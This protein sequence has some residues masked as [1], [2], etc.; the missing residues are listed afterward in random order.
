MKVEITWDCFPRTFN[1]ES[2]ENDPY[3]DGITENHEPAY[4]EFVQAL[5]KLK[6]ESGESLKV[7][8]DV[9]ANIGIK[10]IPASYFTDISYA[11]E[12]NSIA[13][14]SLNSNIRTNGIKNIKTIHSAIGNSNQDQHFLENSA[15]GHIA[16]KGTIVQGQTM[17]SFL[18]TQGVAKVDLCKI[19]I[20]GF[21]FNALS[22]FDF[23]KSK[24]SAIWLEFNSWCLLAFGNTN[25]KSFLE[26]LVAEY[27]FVGQIQRFED[28]KLVV[29]E[30][31]SDNFL[32]FLH[33]NIVVN[34]SVD[35]LLLVPN[36]AEYE[37]FHPILNIIE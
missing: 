19:D 13:I 24:F 26:F 28:D 7:L 30:I 34:G 10:C 20:E 17:S 14:S 37:L 11:V 29:R 33:D 6:N 2:F 22:A 8:M 3:L 21:E 35:D 1:F 5:H 4:L 32:A 18:V 12:A 27:F 9:G 36:Q 23:D 31:N 15:W 16:E 25:P